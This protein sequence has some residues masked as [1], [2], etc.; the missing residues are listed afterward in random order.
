VRFLDR[1]YRLLRLGTDGDVHTAQ[2]LVRRWSELADQV[3][4]NGGA[5]AAATGLLDHDPAEATA[6]L[7]ASAVG[8]TATDGHRL[9]RSRARRHPAAFRGHH[10][11]RRGARGAHARPDRG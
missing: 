11:Q 6:R 10:G 7:V 4:V 9:R 2:A 3:A 5:E 8:G 1:R